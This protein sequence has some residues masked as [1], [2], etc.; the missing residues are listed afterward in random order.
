VLSRASSAARRPCDVNIVV[1]ENGICQKEPARSFG[2][3]LAAVTK[4][5]AVEL[6]VLEAGG[7]GEHEL[8]GEHVLDQS[9]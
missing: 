6:F 9:E 3:E 5:L 4:G 1:L 8:V 7:A 2:V